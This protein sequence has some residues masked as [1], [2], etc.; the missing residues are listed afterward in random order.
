V[1]DTH[2]L[3]HEPLGIVRAHPDAASI[4]HA[5][6]RFCRHEPGAHVI[7]NR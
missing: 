4:V 2:R 5:T 3:G 6:Q 7:L 1:F